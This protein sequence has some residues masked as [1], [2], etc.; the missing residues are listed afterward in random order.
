MYLLDT[1]TVI[2]FLN[3]SL[4]NAAMQFMDTVVDER[5]NISAITKIELL[6]F[7]FTSD[8]EQETMEDFVGGSAVIG[9]DDAIINAAIELR[10]TR[11]IK[12]PDCIIAAT[13]L[14]HGLTVISRNTSDF[15]NIDGLS[16]ISPW[17]K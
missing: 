6:G 3:G 10:K 9:I 12:L 4:P 16:C 13:A 11:K 14:V 7:G 5:C 1:N 15:K 17:D 2:Y 8:A